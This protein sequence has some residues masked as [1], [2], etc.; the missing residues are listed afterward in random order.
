MEDDR[1]TYNQD[2]IA[3]RLQQEVAEARGRHYRPVADALAARGA[4]AVTAR[5]LRGHKL[6]ITAVALAGDDKMLFSSSKD[7]SVLQWDVEAGSKSRIFPAAAKFGKPIYA[8][9]A[10]TDGR[11]SLSL[12]PSL[13]PLILSLPP[14]SQP[15][16][17]PP[18]QLLS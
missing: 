11:F 15:L 10:C 17:I 8:L 14:L 5:L 2:A 1:D 4:A 6:P 7:G 9:A 13:L 3:H 16:S 18:A 12:P